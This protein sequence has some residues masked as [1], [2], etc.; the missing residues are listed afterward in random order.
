MMSV[1]SMTVFVS[2]LLRRMILLWTLTVDAI[3]AVLQAFGNNALI[4]LACLEIF[5]SRINL[6]A[7]ISLRISM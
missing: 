7:R 3:I 4:L 6:H 5:W 2:A 1:S